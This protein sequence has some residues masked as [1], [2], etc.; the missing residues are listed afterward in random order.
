MSHANALVQSDR[1]MLECTGI[2]KNYVRGK[3]TIA[4]LDDINLQVCPGEV[5]VITGKSGA[6]KSTLLR[7][8]GGLERPTSGKITFEG[9][10]LGAISDSAMATLRRSKMGYIFQDTHL[11]SS[12]TA[13]ENVEAPL[14]HIGFPRKQRSA[15]VTS[16]LNELGLGERMD[17]LPAEL[18]AGQKQ[19]VAITRALINQPALL[20]ADEPTGEVDP[21]T[22]QEIT[23]LLLEQVEK[24]G[25]ALVI[26]T[27]GA[28]PVQ[29]IPGMKLFELRDGRLKPVGIL[30]TYT[31]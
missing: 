19:R 7:L 26:A 3:R 10:L 31:R 4:V 2:S 25:L 14:L 24:R 28:F 29:S 12:W 15:M 5:C 20:I 30:S 22:A 21:E 18:S 17:N 9:C 27:H 11:L 1:P 13:F 16:I 6:G 23:A 8:L